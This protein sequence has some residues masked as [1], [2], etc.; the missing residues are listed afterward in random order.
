MPGY[1]VILALHVAGGAVALLAFWTASALRKG[2]SWHRQVGRVFLV[3]MCG[4]LASGVP[5]T[6]Q[7]LLDGEPVAAAFLGYLLVITA[8]AMWM[9]WRAVT[10]KRDWRAMVARRSWRVLMLASVGSGLA[11]LALGIATGSWLVS[12][13]SLIGIVLGVQ[14]GVFERRG[15]RHAN[16]HV[17]QHY[18][19]ML[20]AGIATHVSFLNIAM[21]PAWDW[22]ATHAAVPTVVLQLFPWFAPVAVAVAAGAWLDRK[23]ARRLPTGSRAPEVARV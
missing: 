6:M 12:G 17:V 8:Q 13:F 23:Y 20:G 7:R 3:A 1:S 11:M 21:R 16:W 19:A 4:I 22:L 18:Q 5:I 15:P 10:D 9:G 2:S 14:M